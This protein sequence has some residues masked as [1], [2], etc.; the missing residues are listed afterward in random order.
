MNASSFVSRPLLPH[1]GAIDVPAGVRIAVRRF[2]TAPVG[3]RPA[4]R[5]ARPAV[6]ASGW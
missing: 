6:H 1:A 4:R 3:A 2:R 5:G